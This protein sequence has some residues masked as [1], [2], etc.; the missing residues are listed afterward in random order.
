[1]MVETRPGS[2]S[3]RAGRGKCFQHMIY[4]GIAIYMLIVSTGLAASGE[5]ILMYGWG[6]GTQPVT[7]QFVNASNAAASFGRTL[8]ANH[9]Q[10]EIESCSLSA[11]MSLAKVETVY[12]GRCRLRGKPATDVQIC[13]DTAVGEFDIAPALSGV[14]PKALLIQFAVDHCPGG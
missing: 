12:A 9:K 4:H 8:A 5:Q 6:T 14:D 1:M 2:K 13:Y 3:N 7:V 11:V 10:E